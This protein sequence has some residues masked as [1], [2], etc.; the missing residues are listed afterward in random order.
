MRKYLNKFQV[1]DKLSDHGI[2]QDSVISME[3]NSI[4]PD[5]SSNSVSHSKKRLVNDN[6]VIDLKP[7][8]RLKG[9][10]SNQY[11]P[12]QIYVPIEISLVTYSSIPNRNKKLS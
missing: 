4:V 12:K 1:T 2:K 6:L 9:N 8:K 3:F 7:D 5:V 11:I 10:K